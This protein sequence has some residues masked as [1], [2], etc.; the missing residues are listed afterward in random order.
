MS[1]ILESLLTREAWRLSPL[2]RGCQHRPRG[3]VRLGKPSERPPLAWLI[4]RC[5]LGGG[6]RRP[7]LSGGQPALLC[8][9]FPVCGAG[10]EPSPR[11]SWEL[12]DV[13]CC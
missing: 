4:P 8:L 11:A 6:D 9:G 3:P 10:E 7:G 13:T 2:R 12:G 5:S 1:G